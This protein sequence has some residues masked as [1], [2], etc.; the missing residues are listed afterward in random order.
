[1]YFRDFLLLIGVRCRVRP[2]HRPC[3]LVGELLLRVPAHDH[4]AVRGRHDS[5]SLERRPRVAGERCG[6]RRERPLRDAAESRRREQRW[7]RRPEHILDSH[8]I[9]L[10][11]KFGFIFCFVCLHHMLCCETL[12][13]EKITYLKLKRAGP[14]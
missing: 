14:V 3:E 8:E 7:H 4:G 11:L 10:N 9:T 1:M 13:S 12:I 5:V 6:A 2:G